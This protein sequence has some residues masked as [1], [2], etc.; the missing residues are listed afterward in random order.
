MS[1][2]VKSSTARHN[3]TES[4]RKSVAKQGL[5]DS[6]KPL[7]IF[8]RTETLLHAIL[9]RVVAAPSRNTVR[10]DKTDAVMS[11]RVSRRLTRG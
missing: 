4:N 1:G 5:E 3:I 11:G 9:A 7:E 2:L 10:S 6:R 8:G